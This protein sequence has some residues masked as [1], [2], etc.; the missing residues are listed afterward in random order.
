VFGGV[1]REEGDVE[2]VVLGGISWGMEGERGVR[3]CFPMMPMQ[4]MAGEELSAMAC[5]VAI[6]SLLCG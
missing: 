5:A 3:T 1:R 6:V 2:R 4:A